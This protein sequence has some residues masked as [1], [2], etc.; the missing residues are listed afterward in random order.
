MPLL[1]SNLS[2]R[3]CGGPVTFT[4]ATIFKKCGEKTSLGWQQRYIPYPK[5]RSELPYHFVKT[6]SGLSVKEMCVCV[7][8]GSPLNMLMFTMV[9]ED[10]TSTAASDIIWRLFLLMV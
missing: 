5:I 4:S 9:S 3:T 10:V 7:C 1:T 8:R 6:V 2:H